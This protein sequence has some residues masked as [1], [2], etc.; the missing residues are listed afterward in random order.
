M[1]VGQGH[2]APA[3]EDK[4]FKVHFNHYKQDCRVFLGDEFALDVMQNLC[5]NG[6]WFVYK[7]SKE[8]FAMRLNSPKQVTLCISVILI[9]VGL[10]G[11][12]VAIPYITQ[13]NN[14]ISF[15]GGALLS[16][17]CLIKGL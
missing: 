11:S 9:V 13:F 17:G 15:A 10:V 16:L 5:N 12:L 7:I 14:W 1:P 6:T 8:Y 3:A 2:H 4:G